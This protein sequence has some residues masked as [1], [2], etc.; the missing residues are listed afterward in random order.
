MKLKHRFPKYVYKS[1]HNF[2]I[3]KNASGSKTGI[4]KQSELFLRNVI[5]FNSFTISLLYKYVCF[6]FEKISCNK[7]FNR[8]EP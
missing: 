2:E 8:L 4:P 7:I 3:R 1:S 5:F 6:Y